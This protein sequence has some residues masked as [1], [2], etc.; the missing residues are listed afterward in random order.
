MFHFFTIASM[1]DLAR[2][3]DQV[4]ILP[5]FNNSV[6]GWSV[7]EHADPDV[8]FGGNEGPWEWKGP[9]A[10]GKICVYG[11]FIRD[12][13]AFISP[14]WFGD[15]ANWRRSG[16][17]FDERVEAGMVPHRERLLMN[18]L[19][20]HPY[21]QSR[22]VRRECGIDTGYDTALTRLEMQT[23]VVNQDFQYSIDRFGRPYGWGNAVLCAAEDWVDAFAL[24]VPEDREPEDSFERMIRHLRR[25]MP[26][27]DEKALRRELQ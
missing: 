2:M 23:Y 1:D 14:K 3:I 17:S 26:K 7:E 22:H 19:R 21:T 8:W 10:Y 27:A 20:E 6:P 4:G 15:L 24:A 18:Y 11:K 13:A 5:F 12:K 25:V 9:L 16:M